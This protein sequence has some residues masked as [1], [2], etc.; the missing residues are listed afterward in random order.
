MGYY[1]VSMY[2]VDGIE[3]FENI[4][5]D[6]EEAKNFI[7]ILS[8]Y[9]FFDSFENFKIFNDGAERGN[10]LFIGVDIETVSSCKEAYNNFINNDLNNIFTELKNVITNMSQSNNQDD[11]DNLND[12]LAE[13]NA[14]ISSIVTIQD[15]FDLLDN[16]K[17]W[18]ISQDPYFLSGVE[19]G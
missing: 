13:I 11:I 17:Q 12:A 1:P 2:G 16:F 4:F 14:W 10:N 18:I 8:D 5:G 3:F 15:Y 9:C 6:R 7:S 19:H